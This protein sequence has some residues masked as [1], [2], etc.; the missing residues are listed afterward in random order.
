MQKQ[1]VAVFIE[2]F[3]LSNMLTVRVELER[4]AVVLGC[5]Y[6][7]EQEACT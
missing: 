5:I 4:Q 1:N 6:C 2:N 7:A 3:K